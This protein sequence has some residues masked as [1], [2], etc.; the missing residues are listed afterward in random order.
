MLNM[1]SEK[2][3]NIDVEIKGEDVSLILLVIYLHVW[4]ELCAIIYSWKKIFINVTK[5]VVSSSVK[6]HGNDKYILKVVSSQ[7]V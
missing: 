6:G 5:L 3:Y 2:L 4:W 1:I 7:R